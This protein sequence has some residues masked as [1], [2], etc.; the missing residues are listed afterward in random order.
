MVCDK[1][2]FNS[3][4]YAPNKWCPV[5]NLEI[6]KNIRNSRKKACHWEYP[7]TINFY[8]EVD[9]EPLQY[10][11]V[12]FMTIANVWKPLG[13]AKKSSIWDVTEVLDLLQS[14]FKIFFVPEL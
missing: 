14:S 11:A 1:N 7:V 2:V 13:I 3:A 12:F 4:N 6:L 5:T 10:L 9:L 8:A